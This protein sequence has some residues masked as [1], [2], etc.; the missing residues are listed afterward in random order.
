VYKLILGAVKSMFLMSLFLISFQLKSQV[1]GVKYQL[2]YNIDSCWYDA[3]LIVD[4]GNAIDPQDRIQ[5]YTQYTIVVPAG[6]IIWVAKSYLPLLDNEFYDGTEPVNWNINSV[7]N[8]PEIMPESDFYIFSPSMDDISRYNDLN[9]GDTIKLFSL[10]LD[11][12]T[13][14]GQNIRIFRNGIDP[15]PL[16]PGMGFL[17]CS[18]DFNLTNSPNIY[19]SSENQ[20]NPLLPTF[21]DIPNVSC[22]SGIEIDITIQTSNCQLPL[23]YGWSGPNNFQ[24]NTEDIAISPAISSQSGDYK[25]IATDGLGCRDSLI[26]Y[27][28]NKPS[29]GEDLLICPGTSVN[30]SGSNPISGMWTQV[31]DNN[32]GATISNQNDGNAEVNFDSGSAGVYGFVY[33]TGSCSDTMFITVNA[34]PAIG[35]DAIDTICL[36]ESLHL[37]PSSGGIWTTSDTLVANINNEGIIQSE[38]IGSVIFTYTNLATG[39]SV[40]SSLLNI[41]P[42]P[43]I[44]L[45]GTPELCVGSSTILRTSDIGYWSGWD[46]LLV[47]INDTGLVAGL[48]PGNT[49]MIFTDSNSGCISDAYHMVIH[50]VPEASVTGPNLICIDATTQLSPSNGG[51]W[52][53]NNPSVAIV[54]N[55]GLVQGINSGT[56]TFIWTQT[57]T[58]CY[59]ETLSPIT[60]NTSPTVNL[61]IQEICIGDIVNLI[62][63]MDGTWVSNAPLVANVG[64]STGIVSG[65]SNGEATFTYTNNIDGCSA[66][67]DT[68]TILA[69]PE[70][71]IDMPNIC[72]GSF[73]MLQPAFGGS[74][75]SLDSDIAFIFGNFV[76]GTGAGFVQLLYTDDITG[77][78]NTLTLSVTDRSTVNI[79][80]DM[81]ICEGSTTELTPANG[82][83]W[84]SSNTAVATITDNGIV[85]GISEGQATFT[86]TE[87]ATGCNSLPSDAIT[88]HP[89]PESILMASDSICIGETS[90]F[91]SST[92][93]TWTS[94]NP[95]IASIEPMTGLATAISAGETS[96]I[97]TSLAGCPSLPSPPLTVFQNAIID[98]PIIQE[99]CIGG[100]ITFS[101]SP[102]GIWTSLHPNIAEI[103]PNGQVTT[104]ALG[105]T[106]FTFTDT[107]NRCAYT[108]ITDTL[109]VIHCF[110]PDINF[111][112]I[113]TLTLGNL[114]T[115]DINSV[116]VNYGPLF[117]EI[118]TPTNS[119]Y[120]LN[121]SLDGSYDFMADS[122]GIYIFDISICVPPN[123]VDCPTSYL[124]ITVIDPSKPT[125]TVVANTDYVT[126]FLNTQVNIPTLQ[127]DVCISVGGCLLDNA[128]VNISIPP[129]HGTA[130]INP[131]TGEILYTPNVGYLGLDTLLYEVCSDSE[132]G[133]CDIAYQIINIVA[134]K[135]NNTTV[136]NDDLFTANYGE[137]VIGN[138]LLNDIDA[139]N[140]SQIVTP[141]NITNANGVFVLDNLGNFTF[142]PSKNFK[143]PVN[144]N[145]Q[146]CD[147]NV[148]VSC[149]K[150]TLYIIV[151]PNLEL[152]I[153]VYLEGS[154]L[155]NGNET[156]EGRPL[157]RDNLRHS[158]FTGARYIPNNDP[159]QF[160]NTFFDIRNKYHH[161]GCGEYTRFQTIEMPDSVF[162]INGQN[163]IVD[164]VFVELRSKLDNKIVVATRSGLLQRDGDIVDIDGTSPLQFPDIAIDQYFVSIRHRNH[165]GIMSLNALPVFEL[166][167]LVDFTSMSFPTFDFGTTKNNGYDYTGLAQNSYVYSGFNA[168][169]AGDFDANSKIKASNPNDD[170]NNLFF[171]IFVF[172][173]N[174]LGNSNFDKAY[175]YFQGDYDMNSKS[176]YDNPND[177]RNFVLAQLLFYPQN[178]QFLPN[179]D[180]FI[181]QLP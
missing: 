98:L 152:K 168:M 85:T 109:I 178:I 50:D 36:G 137:V 82:G 11:N 148:A 24:S 65:L 140:D 102:S 179:F 68:L 43:Q 170:I 116:A 138:V 51:S 160:E 163:A 125:K 161:V 172:P 99:T 94:S 121:I 150:A 40:M 180:F 174:T 13:D 31:I 133:N 113:E 47:S 42:I 165:L 141:Q 143:G 126:T 171:E 96:F 54:N 115:N 135:S 122:V 52:V 120:S 159:Y 131:S 45:D 154:L 173:E 155:H 38:G 3:F 56:C 26:I 166:Q 17:D 5:E 66:T 33:T 7:I 158:L 117:N 80:G 169:W 108:T 22:N 19:L 28:E 81:N 74:W 75:T 146:V 136:T 23:S 20:I 79:I 12:I 62:P 147:D 55:D 8:A 9:T 34:I 48:S 25:I 151:L 10:N 90:L 93:G 129:S 110:K 73:T 14:C 71:A 53:S 59:A 18:N 144:F 105:W 49:N 100:T 58:G 64:F 41:L 118:S 101:N 30:L 35:G 89:T 128:S 164:W 104:K 107:T 2:K 139:E 84:S 181:A 157:M 176:K 119:N 29:A 86:F 60:I 156:A 175:G 6:T 70:L 92:S 145:Y 27:A 83:I 72:V 78:E 177:D 114:N 111:T 134:N 61:T 63:N 21:I 88:I 162:G 95:E 37:T 57:T 167:S 106:V 103:T 39:C 149:S 69:Q 1:N 32:I 76:V 77:C 127:N 123:A 153:R 46:P 132:P 67:T 124:N 4:S 44:T 142:S 87:T 112:N 16:E 97:I 130:M 15:G 91:S